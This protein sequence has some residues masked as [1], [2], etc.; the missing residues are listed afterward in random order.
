M[1]PLILSEA[2]IT[3]FL[4]SKVREKIEKRTLEAHDYVNTKTTREPFQ[5]PY[6]EPA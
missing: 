4:C 3:T 6:V 5:I 2:Q 1:R